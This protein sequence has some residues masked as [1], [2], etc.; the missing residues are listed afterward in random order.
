MI[1]L[2]NEGSGLSYH[3]LS[4]RR[5]YRHVK[6]TSSAIYPSQ[7]SSAAQLK[8]CGNSWCSWLNMALFR[9]GPLSLKATSI[10]VSVTTLVTTVDRCAII[11]G[12]KRDVDMFGNRRVSDRIRPVPEPQRLL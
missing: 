6:P 4:Q 12:K 2:I 1:S 3:I 11:S 9:D 5:T 10:Q 7:E 8:S